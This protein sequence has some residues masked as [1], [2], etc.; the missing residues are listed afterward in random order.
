MLAEFGVRHEDSFL[1]SMEKVGVG[2]WKMG[3]ARSLLKVHGFL[4]FLLI[5]ALAALSALALVTSAKPLLNKTLETAITKYGELFPE[6]TIIDGR[7]S[8]RD[9]EPHVV[10]FR[11][12]GDAMV[13]IDTRKGKQPHIVRKLAEVRSG[14]G[15]SRHSL[16]IK[17]HRQI[18]ILPLRNVPDMV[19][20][21]ERLE[22]LKQR[23]LGPALWIGGL[24]LGVYFFFAK[25]VQALVFALFPHLLSRRFSAPMSYG[26]AFKLAIVALIPPVVVDCLL[27]QTG[28]SFATGLFIYVVLY[29]IF[30]FLA[31]RDFAHSEPRSGLTESINP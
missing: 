21:A 31:A 23:Y 12:N 10:D 17:N 22:K 25:L 13:V 7:A 4:I 14:M 11:P 27:M 2:G 29:L 3:L 9:K 16:I 26:Q 6:I 24:T 15:L 5:V 8:I 28:A 19:V 1:R 30:L 20:N 18:R